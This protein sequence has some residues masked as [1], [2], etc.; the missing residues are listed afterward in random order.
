MHVHTIGTNFL[1]SNGKAAGNFLFLKTDCTRVGFRYGVYQ[2]ISTVAGVSY[3]VTFDH[4]DA[5]F[6]HKSP[7]T[8][9]N[10][11]LEV[12]SP[13]GTSV[14]DVS[15]ETSGD[16]MHNAI[17]ASVMG[18][19]DSA[20]YTFTAGGTV[21]RVFFYVGARACPS[22]D[23]VEVRAAAAPTT[24]PGGGPRGGGVPQAVG[25]PHL[26][27]LL[28]QRFDL[29]QPG[30]HMM[31]RVPKSGDS[32]IKITAEVQR[33]SPSCSDIYIQV[34]NVTGQW[35]EQMGDGLLSFEAQKIGNI[36]K[37]W[38]HIGKVKLKVVRGKT[39]TGIRYLNLF[40]RNLA[41]LGMPV[42]GLL[43]DADHTTAAT[44]TSDCFPGVVQLSRQVRSS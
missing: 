33:M 25:D 30:E 21:S 35:V 28:G 5:H 42:G 11:Y 38:H 39:K 9:G 18:L 4:I 10:V 16:L 40:T 20:E 32:L 34:L 17:N 43:G 7:L 26:T 37:T 44:P 29:A 41:N 19:W 22:I 13:V 3:T 2:D 27:N 1:S 24:T 23:N 8:S 6:R 36:A 14:L 15:H 31:V 12:Q